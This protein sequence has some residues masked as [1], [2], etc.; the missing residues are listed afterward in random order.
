MTKFKYVTKD[1]KK[2]EKC[3]QEVSCI[4]HLIGE[5][6]IICLN[7]KTG[8][9]TEKAVIN[10]DKKTGNVGTSNIEH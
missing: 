9:W 6:K 2:C 4:T 5:E 3:K 1:S 10:G 7:E 8:T